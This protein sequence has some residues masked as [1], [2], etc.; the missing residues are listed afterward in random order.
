LAFVQALPDDV[1]YVVQ[2]SKLKLNQ[3]EKKEVEADNKESG[4]YHQ[5]KHIGRTLVKAIMKD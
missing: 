2:H 4:K 5:N 1:K 3:P